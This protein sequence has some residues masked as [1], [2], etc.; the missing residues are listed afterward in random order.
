M[1]ARKIAV[2]LLLFFWLC[3]QCIYCVQLGNEEELLLKQVLQEFDTA[4]EDGGLIA[5]LKFNTRTPHLFQRF[6]Y[7]VLSDTMV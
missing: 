4:Q 7:G 1:D 6:S 5:Q 2:S 3:F